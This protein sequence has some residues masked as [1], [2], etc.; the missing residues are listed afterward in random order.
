[1]CVQKLINRKTT[2][3]ILQCNPHLI[4]GTDHKRVS[5]QKFEPNP[6]NKRDR[7]HIE[8]MNVEVKLEPNEDL[9]HSLV[10]GGISLICAH[11]FILYIKTIC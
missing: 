2:Q 4:F 6:R 1:M 11:S 9:D 5:V 7:V 8:R 3:T 10:S